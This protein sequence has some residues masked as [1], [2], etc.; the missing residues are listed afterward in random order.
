[1]DDNKIKKINKDS[2]NNSDTQN[3]ENSDN[4]SDIKNIED[5]NIEL[6]ELLENIE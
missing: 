5:E 2:D 3:N 1:M 4:N 6:Q